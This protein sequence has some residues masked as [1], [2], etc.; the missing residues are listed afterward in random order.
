MNPPAQLDLFAPRPAPA[1]PSDIERLLAYLTTH[2]GWVPAKQLLADLGFSDRKVRQ[3][4]EQ[5]DA[6]V[7]SWPGSPG[8]RHFSHCTAE[9][10][11]HAADAHISQG[12][13]QIGRGLRIR[14]RAHQTIR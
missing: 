8:Y 4:A 6:L 5:S 9:E 11:A 2:S 10:L 1:P 7:V 13:R 14:K 12:R 3:L